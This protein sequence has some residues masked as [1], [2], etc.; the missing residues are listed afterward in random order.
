MIISDQRHAAMPIEA[1]RNY[2]RRHTTGRTFEEDLANH[3]AAGY[4]YAGPDAFVMARTVPTS[5]DPDLI[6]DSAHWFSDGNCWHIWILAGSISCALRHLP[7]SLPWASFERERRDG[8]NRL[9][10]LAL[11]E[12]TRLAKHGKLP[13]QPRDG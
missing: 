13:T 7:Y 1:A 10:F 3:L 11:P 4:V 8:R 9:V 12:L 5:G 6:T 2:Y